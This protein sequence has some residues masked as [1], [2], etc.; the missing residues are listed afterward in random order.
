MSRQPFRKGDMIPLSRMITHKTSQHPLA[1][2]ELGGNIP[3]ATLEDDKS[4]KEQVE[5]FTNHQS[6]PLLGK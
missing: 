4:T 1:R 5:P 6:C 2:V 3:A